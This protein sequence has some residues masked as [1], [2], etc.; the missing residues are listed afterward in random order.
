[1]NKLLI[2]IV[3][4][5]FAQFVSGQCAQQSVYNCASKSDGAIYVRDFNTRMKPKKNAKHSG[6]RFKINLN[7]GLTYRFYFCNSYGTDNCFEMRLFNRKKDEF[8]KPLCISKLKE[9]G[10]EG[11]DYVCDIKG[12]YWVSIRFRE[13]AHCRKT[14]IVGIAGFIKNK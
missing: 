9:N 5:F 8:T 2:T 4:L 11:F 3:L 7:K 13:G 14:C 6:A 12:E 1:M 10:T